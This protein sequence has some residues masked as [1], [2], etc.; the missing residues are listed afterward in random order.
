MLYRTYYDNTNENNFQFFLIW[1]RSR[2][3]TFLRM[4]IVTAS[5][6][7]SHGLWCDMIFIQRIVSFLSPSLGEGIENTQR[8]G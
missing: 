7:I 6:R 2:D 4:N 5:Y 8:V 3:H 1:N